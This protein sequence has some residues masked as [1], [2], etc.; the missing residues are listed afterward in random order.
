MQHADAKLHRLAAGAKANKIIP[1]ILRTIAKKRLP[2]GAKAASHL[3]STILL[4]EDVDN[5]LDR[6]GAVVLAL[7]SAAEGDSAIL[8]R[9]EGMVLADPDMCPGKHPGA[10]LSHDDIATLCLFSGK[11]LYAEVFRL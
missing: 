1:A 7:A 4:G 5:R 8:K 6:F 2:Q 9:K 11:E 3:I 10:A